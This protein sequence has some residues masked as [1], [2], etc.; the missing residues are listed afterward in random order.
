MC[1][2][3]TRTHACISVKLDPSMTRPG[4]GCQ[5]LKGYLTK[6]P[7]QKHFGAAGRYSRGGHSSV[8]PVDLRDWAINGTVV[9]D[10]EEPHGWDLGKPH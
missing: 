2:P 10:G 3:E 4:Q 8:R 7:G 9:W 1:V 5:D 6:A